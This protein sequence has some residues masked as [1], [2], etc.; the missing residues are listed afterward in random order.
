MANKDKNTIDF[1]MGRADW[2]IHSN[3][4]D[5]KDEMG[6]LVRTAEFQGMKAIA[7]TDHLKGASFMNGKGIPDYFR[8]IDNAASRYPAVEVYKGVE[9]TLLDTDGNLSISKHDIGA[10]NPVLIDF[11]WWVKGVT[12]DAPPDKVQIL[13]NISKSF[14]NL[15]KNETVDIIAHPFN[16]GRLIKDF[17]FSWLSDSFLEEIAGYFL[18]GK[19]YFEVMNNIWWWFPEMSSGEFN[20][21][22]LRIMHIFHSHGVKFSLGSDAH[23]HQGVGDLWYAEM[24][25]K[26]VRGE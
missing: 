11:A 2:H 24:L 22:Y 15:C 4:S 26:K 23:Y 14:A 3:Y 20:E 5:G 16:F 25:L 1:S 19:K 13:K 17:D 12:V 18:G 21:N 8:E 9:G 7:I 10:F 6:L